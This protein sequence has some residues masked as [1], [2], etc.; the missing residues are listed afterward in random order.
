MVK[1]DLVIIEVVITH[2]YMLSRP[3]KKRNIFPDETD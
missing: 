3:F 1:E 2:K